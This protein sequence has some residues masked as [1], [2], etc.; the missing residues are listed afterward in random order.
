MALPEDLSPIPRDPQLTETL[1][2]EDWIPLLAS[3]GNQITHAL[4]LSVC[5]ST[6]IHINNYKNVLKKIYG[7]ENLRCL[8]LSNL[9]PST[10]IV[11]QTFHTKLFAFLA[12]VMSLIRDCGIQKLLSVFQGLLVGG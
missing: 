11:V 5:L 2:A 9:M 3:T 1:D 4:C 12:L 8:R 10:S 7:S 6:C